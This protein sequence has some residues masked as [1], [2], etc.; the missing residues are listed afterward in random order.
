ME[1]RSPEPEPLEVQVGGL[2]REELR[3]ALQARG[4]A[5]NAHAETLLAHPVFDDRAGEPI[6]VVARTVAVLGEPDGATLPGVF[7]AAA[8]QGLRLCPPDTGPYLRL[9]L[10]EQ[11][12]ST[13][14]VLSAGRAPADAITVASP[15]LDDDVDYPKGFY[16]R[17][18]DGRP[19]LRGY[20]C[21]DLHVFAPSDRFAFRQAEDGIGRADGT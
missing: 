17:V 1:N 15:P 21:D 20:R 19:W 14:S 12:D 16:L 4:V 18:V 9:A 7:A 13:D 3:A 8:A 11:A 2:A 10:T 5:L 6:V